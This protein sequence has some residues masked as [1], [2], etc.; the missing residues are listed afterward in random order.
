MATK[1]E[2]LLS[3]LSGVKPTGRDEWS[4]HCPAHEDR[5]PSLS[6]RLEGG[7]ILL[8]CFAGCSVNEIIA[9]LGLALGDLFPDESAPRTAGKEIVATYDYVD[10]QG[11]LLYQAV[12]FRPKGFAQRRPDGLGGWEWKLKGIRRVLYHLPQ[13]LEAIAR[14]HTVYLVEGEKDVAALESLG[15]IATT[16]AGGAGKWQKG[17]TESL[18]GAKLVILPD[19][20]PPGQKHALVIAAACREI[21]ASVKVIYLPGLPDKGDVSDWLAGGHTR[22]ELQTL[23]EQ[24]EEWTAPPTTGRTYPLTDLGNAERLVAG[25]GDTLRFLAATAHWYWWTGKTW[26]CDTLGEIP[27]RAMETVRAIKAEAD[28]VSDPL[29]QAELGKHMRRSESAR[30]LTAMLD[31]ARWQTGIAIP[32]TEF[33]RDPW[34]V[35]CL[36]GILD[37]R[38]GALR[39]HDPE[40]THSKLSPVPYDPAAECPQWLRFLAEVFEG[41]QPLI[42]YVCRLA[43]YLLTGI[44]REQEVYVLVGKGSN[45]KRILLD[46]IRAVMG[47][48]AADT[49]VSTF[50]ERRSDTASNDLAALVGARMVTASEASSGQRFDDALL[51]KLSGGDPVTCRFL[52]R[53]FFTYTPAYKVVFSTNNVP[54]LEYSQ[55]YAIRRRMRIVPFRLTFHQ[56]WEGMGPV[57]DEGLFDR[58]QGEHAGILAWMVRGCLK[59]QQ[60]GLAPPLEVLAETSDVMDRMDPLSEWLEEW[61]VVRPGLMV[62]V[63]DLWNCYHNW[64]E[65]VKTR[66]HYRAPATLSR[67]LQSRQGITAHHRRDGRYLG[68]I[69]IQGQEKEQP[70]LSGE[71]IGGIDDP[72]RESGDP[73]ET[74]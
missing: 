36:N 57:R 17:Y 54:H 64:C 21:A 9:P 10:E 3:Q 18:A 72:R 53:E 56:P 13:I 60:E 33:N 55:S 14:G 52:H 48:Y 44:T 43:G 29:W 6:I 66:P 1:I 12:R 69:S 62:S 15:L 11:R 34:Q 41:S 19:A 47:D 40:A 20:D 24:A 65:S 8:H 45:G 42:E 30:S 50:L 73:W 23:V 67:A 46:T 37:L 51:K 22:E 68:G 26:A 28:L 27:R 71:A 63:A 25:Y 38:T 2:A 59:W 49:P 5:N 61:C 32:A 70:E 39:E 74:E 58:L 4:A 16:N 31:L 35:N 7:K